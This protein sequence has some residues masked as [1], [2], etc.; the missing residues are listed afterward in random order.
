MAL[1]PFFGLRI[2]QHMFL[3]IT[4]LATF[5]ISMTGRFTLQNLGGSDPPFLFSHYQK[6][7][8]VYPH[9]YGNIM[10]LAPF[11]RLILS[12]PPHKAYHNRLYIYIYIC[13]P[14]SSFSVW[15]LSGNSPEKTNP[16]A[17]FLH[18][19]KIQAL[20]KPAVER[21]SIHQVD[22]EAILAT[23]FFLMAIVDLPPPPRNSWPS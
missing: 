23:A 18:I 2:M 5:I 3:W 9:H 6:L 22:E 11:H 21:H 8:E 7:V 15:N 1:T 12:K 4:G 17:E 13:I 19:W 10:L 14:G 16:K 20:R